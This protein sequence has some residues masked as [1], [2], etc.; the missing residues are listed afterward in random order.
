[1]GGGSLK[2]QLAQG[3]TGTENVTTDVVCA[4]SFERIL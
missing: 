1:M 2:F 3:L 4:H